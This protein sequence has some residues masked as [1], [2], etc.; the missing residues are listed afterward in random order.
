MSWHY[1]ELKEISTGYFA[2]E[3]DSEEEAL[4]RFDEW[5][6]NDE[7]VMNVMLGTDNITSEISIVSDSEVPWGVDEDDMLSEQAYLAL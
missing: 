4:R 7:H 6:I 2:V 3:A 5:S 1:I